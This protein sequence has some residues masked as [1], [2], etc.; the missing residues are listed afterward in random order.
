MAQEGLKN[1]DQSLQELESLVKELEN[2]NLSIDEAIE[3]YTQGMK[4]AVECKRSLSDMSRKVELVRAKAQQEMN[5][6]EAAD[7]AP[8]GTPGSAQGALPSAAQPAL[9]QGQWQGEP[10]GIPN[11]VPG[12]GMPGTGMPGGSW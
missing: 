10:A 9:A 8:G 3:K 6:L 2:S 11:G 7:A 4:L 5:A 12:T 1:L